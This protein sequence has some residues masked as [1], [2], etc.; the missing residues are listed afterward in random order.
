MASRV[1]LFLCLWLLFDLAGVH[2][3]FQKNLS[4]H[5]SNQWV[6]REPKPVFLQRRSEFIGCHYRCCQNKLVISKGAN[7]C[8]NHCHELR[9][10]PHDTGCRWSLWGVSWVVFLSFV[11]RTYSACIPFIYCRFGSSSLLPPYFIPLSGHTPSRT[12]P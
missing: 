6:S 2:C 10:G 5:V 11:I 9:Q 12:R 7:D 8:G 1:G 3:R 4:R